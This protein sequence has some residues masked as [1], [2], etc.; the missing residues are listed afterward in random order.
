MTRI[1]A[2]TLWRPWA[3][4]F[5]DLPEPVAKRV[6]NRTWRTYHRGPVYLHA[7]GRFDTGAFTVARTAVSIL[8]ADGI[9]VGRVRVCLDLGALLSH[10]PAD[11]PTGI[12]AIANLVDIC[13]ASLYTTH[14]EC[15]CGPWAFPRQRHWQFANVRPLPQPIPCPGSQQ[16]W[17]P[18]REVAAWVADQITN[19]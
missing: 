15:A 8:G 11:H 4:C 12:V 19:P 18:S 6:E 13:Q 3:A 7:G 10:K 9:H 14:L 17:Y 16:L 5:T 2:L 1:P